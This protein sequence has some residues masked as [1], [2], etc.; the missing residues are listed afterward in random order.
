MLNLEKSST[1]LRLLLPEVIG[2]EPEQF[3]QAREMS[4][5]AR[6][7][8]QQWQTYLNTLGI[9][10]FE[11][12]LK[13][14]IPEQAIN[15][16]PNLIES[17]CQLKVG[18]FKIG[19]IATEHILDEVVHVPQTAINSSDEAVHF[20]V[21]LE[22]AEEQEEV[23][24]RGFLRY[25][26]LLNYRRKVNLQLSQD[27]SYQIPLSLFDAESNHLLFYCRHLEP[28][29]ILLPVAFPQSV[30]DS[31]ISVVES[32][33]AKLSQWLEGIFDPGWLSIDA[34]LGS[35][36][37]LVWSTRARL[38]GSRM[39]KLIN[40][41]I[42]LGDHTIAMLV[43]VKPEE[44]EKIGIEI[45]LSPIRGERYLPS[46]TQLTLYS[47]SGRKLQSTQSREQDNYIQLKPFKGKEGI[48]F[49]VEVSIGDVSV[50]EDFEL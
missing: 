11:E 21:V 33:R 47:K 50:I 4:N 39:G 9:S 14:R 42:E 19:L 37:N 25:D 3:Q 18:E 16:Q 32:G 45:Q 23:I 24:I 43:T 7:E 12:W 46:N 10:A 38:Q 26:E 49:S 13:E 5:Q 27:S 41:G 29:V 8:A 1:D 34:L 22:V 28:S 20:Y 35:E 31:L 48:E 17:I 44:S 36:A 40:L 2:L 6:S 30:P 15:R